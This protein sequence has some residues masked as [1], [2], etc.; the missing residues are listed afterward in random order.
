MKWLGPAWF[1]LMPFLT[2][3]MPYIGVNQAFMMIGS[4]TNRWEAERDESD[5][6]AAGCHSSQRLACKRLEEAIT[7]NFSL[8]STCIGL[9]G[10]GAE[11]QS[12][13]I[14]Y[15][16]SGQR[17]SWAMNT[18]PMALAILAW[19]LRKCLSPCHKPDRTWYMCDSICQEAS[20]KQLS[21]QTERV[22]APR[23][24]RCR[25]SGASAFRGHRFRDTMALQIRANCCNSNMFIYLLWCDPTCVYL[26]A[27]LS[28]LTIVFQCLHV[29]EPFNATADDW[30][31][32]CTWLHVEFTWVGQIYI[33]I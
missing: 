27:M 21:F 22:A 1:V 6:I 23:L 13:P 33:Y 25:G 16:L 26:R 7:Q 29:T 5:M 4:T 10:H 9:I 12:I 2:L 3:F 11:T 20:S 28:K 30:H 24:K 14:V 17:R 8:T 15:T 31:K 19:V 18:H 32:K